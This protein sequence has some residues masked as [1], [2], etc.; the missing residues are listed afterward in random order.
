MKVRRNACSRVLNSRDGCVCSRL[1]TAVEIVDQDETAVAFPNPKVLD[2]GGG[3]SVIQPKG[4]TTATEFSVIVGQGLNRHKVKFSSGTR[5]V[6]LAKELQ[7]P[8]REEPRQL[9]MVA[10]RHIPGCTVCRDLY[11][12]YRTP[13][14][15]VRRGG[16]GWTGQ[17]CFVITL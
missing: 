11:P 8:V 10:F 9:T 13:D 7:Q 16:G 4:S 14:G 17:C 3:T 1:P 2:R 15:Q 5:Q 6:D 12:H